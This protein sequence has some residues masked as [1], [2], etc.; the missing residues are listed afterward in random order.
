MN[1]GAQ[2]IS[3]NY[4]TKLLAGGRIVTGANSRVMLTRNK[5]TMLIGPGSVVSLPRSTGSGSKTTVLQ[6]A[7]TVLLDVEKRNVKHFAV[8]TPYL[9]AVVKGTR[10]SVTVT[11]KGAKVTVYRGLVEVAEFGRGEVALVRPGQSAS[12]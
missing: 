6:Q 9:A 12:A 3:L 8:E 5:E 1:T 7:G 10:F 2:K 4:K 11:S